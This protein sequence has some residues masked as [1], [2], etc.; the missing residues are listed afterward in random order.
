MS[1]SRKSSTT[2]HGNSCEMSISAARGAIRSRASCLTRLRSSRCSSLRTSQGTRVSLFRLVADGLDVVAV[3]V[4]HERA[5]V[6]LVVPAHTRRA[7]VRA[8]GGETR[9]VERVD[10][11]PVLGREREVYSGRVGLDRKSTR[12]NS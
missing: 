3:G 7:V 2:S 5:V 6:V 10:G 12:L 4:E 1:F 9:G 11:R 8:A